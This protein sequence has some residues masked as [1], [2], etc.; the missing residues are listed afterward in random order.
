MYVRSE[1]LISRDRNVEGGN[2]FEVGQEG[3]NLCEECAP[4]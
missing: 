3:Q 4:G 1:G 2:K